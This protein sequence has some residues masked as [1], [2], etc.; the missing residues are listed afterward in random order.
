MRNRTVTAR[1]TT[2]NVPGL[3]WISAQS[4][5]K[6]L[7]EN[8]LRV[9]RPYLGAVL[10]R[11]HRLAR[12]R[13][14][15]RVR[16]WDLQNWR[17]VWFS[18]ESRFMLQKIDGCTRVYKRRNERFRKELRPWGRQFR[19]RKCDDVGCHILRLKTHLVHIPGNLIAARY[20]DEFLTPHM[21]PAMNL[22]R[23]VFQRDNA[24]RHTARATK[25]NSAPLAA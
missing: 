18:D 4:V 9:R 2:S 14:C 16:V 13:W 6:R 24:R 22:R 17:Q 3:P 7:G 10:R 23:E 20:R 21:L 15:N 19:R 11:R 5:R 1:E 25:R 8:G 12:V